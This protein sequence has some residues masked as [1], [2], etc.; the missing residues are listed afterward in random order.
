MF[1]VIIKQLLVMV[2]CFNACKES[3][4]YH[5][6]SQ[7]AIK[8]SGHSMTI[9]AWLFIASLLLFIKT[10]FSFHWQ[11]KL[12]LSCFVLFDAQNKGQP[13][14]IRMGL[15]LLLFSKELSSIQDIWLKCIR[16]FL[17]V[18]FWKVWWYLINSREK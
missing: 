8:I 18:S 12:I 10:L 5:C 9:G 4:S 7:L 17:G 16:I 1:E 3:Y 14:C 11:D 15:N 2:L 13:D 6:G